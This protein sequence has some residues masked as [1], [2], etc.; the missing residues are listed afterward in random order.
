[1][2]TLAIVLGVALTQPAFADRQQFPPLDQATQDP[3]LVTF[4]EEL[5]QAVAARDIER[6]VSV[7]CPDIYLS[8][9]GN[10]GPA[11]LR[12]NLTRPLETSGEPER[13]QADAL[14]EA[15]WDNLAE[16]ISS[17]GYFDDEGEFWMPTQWGIRLPPE[18]DPFQTY[19]VDGTRVSLRQGSGRDSPLLQTISHELVTVSAFDLE[20]DY[21]NVLLT[22]GTTG[23]MHRDFLWSM[24]GHRAAFYKTRQGIW[25]LCTFVSGD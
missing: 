4:R 15:Y 2:R 14:R 25:Q 12:Q 16:T 13:D 11:E 21:Q 24:V 10:G 20:Q 9:G 5:K 3:S 8:H 19:F 17:A 23:Y 7:A 18:L 6:V 1:M 22:D